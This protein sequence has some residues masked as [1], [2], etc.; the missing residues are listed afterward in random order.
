MVHLRPSFWKVEDFA[1]LKRVWALQAEVLHELEG[2]QISDE[3][4]KETMGLKN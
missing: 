2:N 1:E 3:P 4:W